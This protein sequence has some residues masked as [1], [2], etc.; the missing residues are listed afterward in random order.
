M[1]LLSS[2]LKLMFRVF[3]TDL[4]DI[5]SGPKPRSVPESKVL[6][7]HNRVPCECQLGSKMI[8][9]VL[10][11]YKGTQDCSTIGFIVKIKFCFHVCSNS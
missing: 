5:L 11:G 3:E 1:I 7:S 9:G 2:E 4:I 6:V 8:R 10:T